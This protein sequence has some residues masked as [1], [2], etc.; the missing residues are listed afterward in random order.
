MKAAPARISLSAWEA[1]Y[2]TLQ[3]AGPHAATYDGPLGRHLVEGDH[4]LATLAF[5]NSVAALRLWN[6]LLTEEERLREARAAGK[7]LVGA[8]KDLGTVPVLA[9]AA[10]NVVA[11]YPDGA[12]WI[13]CI[14]EMSAG[15]LAVADRLGI[16][17]SFCPVRAVLGAFETEA[18]F[19]I[20]DLL[21]CS[22]GA[23]CDDFSVI[24]QRLESRGRHILWWEIPHRRTPRPAEDAVELADGVHV[25][26]VQL[27]LVQAELTRVRDAVSELAGI[28]LDDALLAEGIRVAN[29]V[30]RL[31]NTLRH[32]VF[33]AAFCPLPALELLIAE[34]LALHYCSDRAETIAVLEELQVEVDR[35][36]AEGVGISPADTARVFWVNPVADLRAMNLL[37]DCGAR[38][39]GTDFMFCHA[40]DE[41]DETVPPLEAL[42]RAALADPMAGTSDSRA[43]RVCRDARR[44]KA[45]AVVVSRIPGASHCATEGGRI[46]ETVETELGL[47]AIE[48]E[49]PPLCDGLEPA[50]RTRLEAL[51][52]TVMERR[53]Q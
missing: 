8:M 5:D 9:Y 2:A 12:W 43:L 3:A 7:K 20:P 4:R 46:C 25:P 34:M 10:P 18:H 37:E 44:W 35:R 51:V 52:E 29:H 23:T 1:R 33:S 32:A 31:L 47:P 24:A 49:V 26:Q 15:L 17:D 11:F 36:I 27:E 14:M 28:T 41:L 13:P 42:A 45:E 30:R 53:C 38:L 22:V 21:T 16:D 6:F 50:L 48:I 39:C 19:P 40:L